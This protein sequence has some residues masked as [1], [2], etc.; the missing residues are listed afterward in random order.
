MGF[1]GFADFIDHGLFHMRPGNQHVVRQIGTADDD[2]E[3]AWLYT[4]LMTMRAQED[5]ICGADGS[6]IPAPQA[7][8][9][10]IVSDM[11]CH[12]VL[13]RIQAMVFEQLHRSQVF[14]GR[15][16]GSEG[17]FFPRQAVETGDAL[18]SHHD[19]Y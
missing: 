19:D 14:R 12:N 9:G 8:P 16:H 17:D 11:H 7:L 13:E 3:S 10:N 1:K 18:V 15:A 5:R 4:L 6:D 2:S